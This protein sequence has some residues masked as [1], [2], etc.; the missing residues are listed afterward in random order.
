MGD[1]KDT[2]SEIGERFVHENY[3][4]LFRHHTVVKCERNTKIKGREKTEGAD[5]EAAYRFSHKE[6]LKDEELKKI[7]G[8]MIC[9]IIDGYLFGPIEVKTSAFEQY[10]AFR[11]KKV[12]KQGILPF[13]I[14]NSNNNVG[15][16]ERQ[17]T[18]LGSLYRMFYPKDATKERFPI[19]YVAVFM[20][21]ENVPYACLTFENF[22]AL[23]KRL[24]E[25]GR[26]E[27]LD[28]TEEGFNNIP[29]WNRENELGSPDKWARQ[30]MKENPELLLMGNMWYV[31]MSDVIDLATVVLIGEPPRIVNGF[32]DCTEELQ[33]AR[34][35]YLV[36]KSEA[37]IPLEIDEE[38]QI[39]QERRTAVFNHSMQFPAKTV[40][41]EGHYSDLFEKG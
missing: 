40:E 18:K 37:T 20:N 30:K 27:G 25:V 1:Y 34:W 23:K 36:E 16:K 15:V 35:E 11:H 4:R 22:E 19:A 28:L 29:C 10:I 21:M 12:D 33:K 9:Y 24:I 2:I 39:I 26:K 17:R 38:S 5:L 7:V 14:W 13:A 3:A 6:K 31:K 8:D 41:T 32:N